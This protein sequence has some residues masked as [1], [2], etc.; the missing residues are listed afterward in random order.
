VIP[1]VDLQAQYASIKHE[2]DAAI[3][4]VL[5]SCQFTLGDEV[6]A[7][8]QEFAAYCQSKHGIGV[9]TGTSALHLALLAADV[10]PGDEVI[11]VPFTFVAT[12]AAIY[13]TGAKP[14][15]VDVDP[16][17]FNMD[18]GALESAITARTRAIIPVHL[19]GHPADM[20]PILQIAK[21]RGLI[22][23]EDACQAHG[24]QYKGRRAG[25]LGDMGCF[26]FYPGKNL[27]AYG[28]GGMVVTGNA[29]YART[30]RMLRDW[31]AEK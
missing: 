25:S 4:G 31:G 10:G 21:K 12:V 26:S 13:Y 11:T 18:A 29:Q 27:G 23:I 28:E 2:V 3:Q 1:F 14:V 30:I 5:D 8:E 22:V 20:D 9:N 7:F 19:Y 24:A 15:F 17:T 16:Q 6:A